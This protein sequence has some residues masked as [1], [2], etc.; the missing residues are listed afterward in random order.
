M[1]F[2]VK[3]KS[4]LKAN[5]L[6][7]IQYAVFGACHVVEHRGRVGSKIAF[8]CARRII[9]MDVAIRLRLCLRAKMSIAL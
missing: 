4:L 2:E 8:D 6:N 9:M 1:I 5:T 3:V 7:V